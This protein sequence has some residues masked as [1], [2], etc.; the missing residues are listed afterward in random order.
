MFGQGAN[1]AS[2]QSRQLK[3]DAS[4]SVVDRLIPEVPARCGTRVA[5]PRGGPPARRKV[6]EVYTLPPGTTLVARVSTSVAQSATQGDRAVANER[7]TEDFVRHLKTQGVRGQRVEE[8]TS[9]V[10]A[11]KRALT[12]SGQP[13]WGVADK[14]MRALPLANALFAER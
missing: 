12:G 1:Q 4:L 10:P 11:I 7:T 5:R 9:W 3:D 8:Q 13:D 14:Y 2:S 6:T